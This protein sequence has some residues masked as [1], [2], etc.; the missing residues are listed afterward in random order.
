MDDWPAPSPLKKI[1][2]KENPR[3]LK[4]A[5]ELKNVERNNKKYKEVYKKVYKA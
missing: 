2:K 3:N 5:I 4:M 1:L